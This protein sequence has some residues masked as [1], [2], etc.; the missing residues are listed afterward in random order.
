MFNRELRMKVI[1]PNKTE[2]TG[3]EATFE[4]KAKVVVHILDGI[5]LRA[6][7][8]LCAYMVLDT[9]RQILIARNT[10]I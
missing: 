5:A 3:S 2:L 7:A 10:D 6:A 9:Y 4:D 1:K 8:G